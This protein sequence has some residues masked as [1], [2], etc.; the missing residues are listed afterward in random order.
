MLLFPTL[1]SIHVL[2]EMK[3]NIDLVDEEHE[4]ENEESR[5]SDD[6]SEGEEPRIKEVWSNLSQALSKELASYLLHS[7]ATSIDILFWFSRGQ[8]L[9]KKC[10]I[11]VTSSPS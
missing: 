1:P 8:L 11:P 4:S 9:R 7:M 2:I 6:E 3:R 10:I 5:S